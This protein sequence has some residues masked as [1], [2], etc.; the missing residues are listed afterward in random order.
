MIESLITS[1]TRVRLLLKFFLNPAMQAYLRE[2]SDEFGESTNGI[3][4]ELNRLT[5][6]GLLE[7]EAKGN[8]L[9]YRASASHPLFN[10]ITSI[11]AKYVGLDRIVEDIIRQLGTVHAAYITGDYARGKDSGVVDLMVVGQVDKVY[12]LTLTEKAEKFIHR[13][14]RFLTVLPEEADRWIENEYAVLIWKKD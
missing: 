13:K 14:I 4:I 5:Q 2:L 9:L 1:K 3:R 7:T 10:E 11:V 12:L 6:A 8:T